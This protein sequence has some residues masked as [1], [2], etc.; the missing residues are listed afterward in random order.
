VKIFLTPGFRNVWV[1]TLS[2]ALAASIM[3]LMILVGSLVGAELAPSSTWATLPI[4]LTVIGTAVGI[5]PATT[6]MQL[7]GRKYSLWA[8]MALGVA[9]CW[10][11]SSA[12]Q[13]QSFSLFCTAAVLLGATNAALQQTR[14]A[15]MEAVA[16]EFA[17]S[18]AS[19]I[20]CGGILA[21]IIGPEL[22]IAGIHFTAVDY[23]GSFW[24][25]AATL[26]VG[27]LILTFYK[28]TTVSKVQ[29]TTSAS[30]TRSILCNPTFLVAM[31][32]G[33][34]GFAVMSF[35]MTG[36]PISMHHNYGHSLVDTKWVIQSH[37]AAMFL[38]SLIAPLLF[39]RLGIRGMMVTGLSCYCVTI[40]I[41]YFDTSVNGFWAQ[42][43]LLGVGWNFLFVSGTALLPTA[44]AEQDKFKGQAIND[45]SIF[46]I[47]ALASVSA[48]WALGLINWQ[49]MLM[50][51]LLPVLLMAALLLIENQINRRDTHSH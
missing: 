48:G 8:F 32:S 10:L 34:V 51:C 19:L 23:Q 37:I 4:A 28:P 29:R 14:F 26:V 12:L 22:A 7:L 3:T 44:Y 36:T 15:A 30:A 2:N 41:G 35:I 38:P 16:P 43:V 40:G 18:A 25:A 50:I 13:Q 21:A 17:P 33:A 11:A 9:A 27:A 49:Q 46:T 31:S 47:Q 39:Q 1:L 42:L 6:C 24:L 5:L 45:L 20:M